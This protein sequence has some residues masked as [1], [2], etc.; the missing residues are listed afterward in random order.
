MI[1]SLPPGMAVPLTSLYLHATS[2]SG[3]DLKI[4]NLSQFRIPARIINYVTEE[5]QPLH[6]RSLT[7]A[8]HETRT[9]QA[10]RSAHT[11][12]APQQLTHGQHEDCLYT[13]V[14][15]P[16]NRRTPKICDASRAQ[17]SKVLEP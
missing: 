13:E 10:L 9:L 6:S 1:S 12:H 3:P 11:A 16:S 8:L 5:V 4:V 7:F 15:S 17:N 14:M 2:L